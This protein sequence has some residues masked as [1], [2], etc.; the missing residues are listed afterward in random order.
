MVNNHFHEEYFYQGTIIKLRYS[1]DNRYG[2]AGWYWEVFRNGER[3]ADNSK[4]CPNA[5]NE[6]ALWYAKDAID[7]S[8]DIYTKS[9]PVLLLTY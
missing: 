4:S 6:Q 1:L 3:L 7:L 8:L 2:D 5:T 9:E